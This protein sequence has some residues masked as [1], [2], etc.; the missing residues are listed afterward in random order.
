MIWTICVKLIFLF[1]KK[2]KKKKDE[3]EEGEISSNDEREEEFD[4]GLDED[5]I[6]K[7]NFD[8]VSYSILPTAVGKMIWP[9][10]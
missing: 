7:Q 1:Q 5:L 8:H 3:S 10:L 9:F 2:G 4:D 6:G